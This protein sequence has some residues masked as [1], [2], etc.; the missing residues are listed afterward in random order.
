MGKTSQA[1][2]VIHNL[3]GDLGHICLNLDYRDTCPRCG[4]E[5]NL[6]LCHAID[7]AAGQ[8]IHRECEGKP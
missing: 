3:F 5:I 4:E 7:R 8:P 1:V 2:D 6:A